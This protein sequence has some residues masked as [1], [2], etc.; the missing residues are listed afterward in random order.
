MNTRLLRYVR[1]PSG[2]A[3]WK[4]GEL[5]YAHRWHVSTSPREVVRRYVQMMLRAGGP[6]CEQL[7][8]HRRDDRRALYLGTLSG[9]RAN[10]RLMLAFAL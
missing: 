6:A 10:R 7:R 9:L 4:H 5:V 8:P 2:R 3:A 1:T